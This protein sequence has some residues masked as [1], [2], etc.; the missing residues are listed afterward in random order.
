VQETKADVTPPT[1][2]PPT[3]DANDALSAR[4]GP[5]AN[6]FGLAVGNGGGT[7]IGGGTGGDAFMAYVSVVQSEVRK[8]IE[9]D[10]TLKRA[11]YSVRVMLKISADGVIQDIELTD[12]DGDEDRDAVIKKILAS[13]TF[14]RKPPSGLPP[15]RLQLASSR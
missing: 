1:P 2:T 3:P 10:P 14:S 11:T 12:P 9:N 6:N 4:E 8:A 13:M 7:R 15:V 5:A